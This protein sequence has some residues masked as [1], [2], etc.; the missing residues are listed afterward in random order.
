MYVYVISAGDL[1][2]KVGVAKDPDQR[3]RDLQCGSADK[4]F[5]V[6]REQIGPR[7]IEIEHAAHGLLRN[8]R[9]QLE[10]FAVS[11]EDAIDAIR[12]AVA[13][14]RAPKPRPK[15]PKWCDRNPP[16]S[17]R[18]AP[19]VL[20]AVDVKAGT[21]GLTRHAALVQAV[22]AWVSGPSEVV[23]TPAPL[24]IVVRDDPKPK[25]AKPWVPHPK[26]GKR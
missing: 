5:V 16:I 3:C 17:L 25:P 19:D 9:L 1:R 11:G 8:K 14:E 18:L 13:G 24:R 15:G 12:R 22:G 21:L 7:A 23:T 10:W 26:P 6:H 4:L 2:H 20:A